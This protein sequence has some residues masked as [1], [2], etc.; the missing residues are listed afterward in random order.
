MI[1]EKREAVRNLIIDGHKRKRAL[2]IVGITE[3]EYAVIG[4][5]K[6][7][8]KVKYKDKYPEV[9]PWRCPTCRK[10]INIP[11]CL[12]CRDR[13]TVRWRKFNVN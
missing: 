6:R 12:Y 10:M 8:H 2:E 3:Q 9:V 13:R 5:R 1:E 11:E 4:E 7:K